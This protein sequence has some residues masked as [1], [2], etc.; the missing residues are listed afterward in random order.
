MVTVPIKLVPPVTADGEKLTFVTVVGGTT[1]TLAVT[2]I[3]PVVAVSVTVVGADT[4]PAVT[5]NV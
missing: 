2:I 4:A 3:V 1:V 5:V